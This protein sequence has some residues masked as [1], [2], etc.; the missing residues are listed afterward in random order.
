V[1]LLLLT[2]KKKNRVAT[3]LFQKIENLSAKT[4]EVSCFEEIGGL[5]FVFD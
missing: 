5:F 3:A 1:S 4:G 2:K